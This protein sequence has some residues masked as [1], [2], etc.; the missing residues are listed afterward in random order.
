MPGSTHYHLPAASPHRPTLAL[1]G[2]LGRLGRLGTAHRTRLA[3]F[4]PLAL[5]HQQ[6][7]RV[8]SEAPLQA[9]RRCMQKS[10]S[11]LRV[12][13]LTQTGL[14]G[15]LGT[16]CRQG[17]EERCLRA[18]RT[19]FRQGKNPHR[20]QGWTLCQGREWRS[21]GAALMM[22]L[23]DKNPRR[24]HG[25]TLHLGQGDLRQT[26]T[27]LKRGSSDRTDGDRAGPLKGSRRT[28]WTA[29]PASQSG[30]PLLEA[31]SGTC[32]RQGS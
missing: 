28:I 22:F 20:E 21:R 13:L 18:P 14:T 5:C 19:T 16:S 15:L 10:D 17:Q 23:R 7:G 30:E 8:A 26:R 3:L 24:G 11:H 1:P 2:R 6:C 12:V 32:R 29:A 25:R 4:G 31:S 27:G 9:E